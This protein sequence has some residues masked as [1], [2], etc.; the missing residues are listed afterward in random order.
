MV[1]ALGRKGYRVDVL[2]N[3]PVAPAAF[4]R[5]CRRRISTADP[6]HDPEAFVAD[7]VAALA[8][9][10]YEAFLPL[11]DATMDAVI[12]ARSEIERLV[13]VALPDLSAYTIAQDKWLTL[14]VARD[15]GVSGP[16][17]MRPGDRTNAEYDAQAVGFPLVIKPTKSSG[18]RGLRFVANVREFRSAYDSVAAQYDRPILQQSIP[19]A[20]EGVGVGILADTGKVVTTFSY[21]RLR[22][23]PIS[24]GPSTLRE[25]TDDPDLKRRAVAL[26]ERLN[27]HGLAMVEFK[28]DARGEPQLMEIN[29]RPWGS[30]A[31]ALHA[32]VDFAS[33]WVDLASGRRLGPQS[34]RVGARCR[35]LLPGDIAHFIA[36]PHRFSMRP[37]FFEFTGSDLAYDEFDPK[38]VRGNVGALICTVAS[39]FDPKTWRLGVFRS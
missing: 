33:L 18:S 38:D 10:E 8:A 7:V 39:A 34:Y 5:Y 23:F 26:M 30:I 15:V 25:S 29:P 11:E 19:R 14:Q 9:D 1:R 21:R 24:G 36:N 32:G 37:S 12:S 16:L 4:S 2:S 27:W 22:E 6:S 20:G 28:R 17:T 31:L 13:P 35:W 3:T